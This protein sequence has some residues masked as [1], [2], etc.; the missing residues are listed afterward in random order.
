[1]RAVQRQERCVRAEE[2]GGRV[3]RVHKA[4]EGQVPAARTPLHNHLVGARVRAA[5]EEEARERRARLQLHERFARTI[6][7]SGQQIAYCGTCEHVN[8]NAE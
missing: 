3:R 1:M 4:M 2:R 7:Q 5:D 6:E 8:G